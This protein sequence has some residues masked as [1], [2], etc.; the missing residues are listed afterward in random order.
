MGANNADFAVETRFTPG[1]SAHRVSAI[2]RLTGEEI[3]YLTVANPDVL[4][5]SEVMDIHVD[6]DHRRKGIATKMWNH[7]Y[8]EMYDRHGTPPEH[9]WS[10]MTPEGAAWA[11]A[12]GD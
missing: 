6:E 3:G 9:D 12:V 10:Q 8:D 2:N 7:M 1:G 5:S 4:R 11:K